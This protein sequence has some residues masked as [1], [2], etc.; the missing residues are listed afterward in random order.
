M[1]SYKTAAAAAIS[2]GLK[3]KAQKTARTAP[4]PKGPPTGVAQPNVAPPRTAPWPHPRKN[5]PT[6]Q[7]SLSYA[8]SIAQPRAAAR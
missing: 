3:P 7:C 6:R 4:T 5:P 2:G 8:P 1:D